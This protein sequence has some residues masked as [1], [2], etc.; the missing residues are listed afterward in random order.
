MTVGI[1][2]PTQ[3][4]IVSRTSQRGRE[5]LQSFITRLPVQQNIEQN[6]RIYMSKFGISFNARY[7]NFL[8][9]I[10]S[11]RLESDPHCDF[12]DCDATLNVLYRQSRAMYSLPIEVQLSIKLYTAIAHHKI[13]LSVN[14]T[15]QLASHIENIKFAFSKIQPIQEEIVVYA[16]VLNQGI[17]TFRFISAS[18]SREYVIQENHKHRNFPQYPAIACITI[19]PGVKVLPVYAIHESQ[20]AGLNEVLIDPKSK[21]NKIEQKVDNDVNYIYYLVTP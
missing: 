7:Q 20:V 2:D 13:N 9:Y 5:L 12:G 10:I 21:I 18:I 11:T 19:K 16:N 15:P 8:R 14:I 17:S 4:R 3:N 1:F 6:Y